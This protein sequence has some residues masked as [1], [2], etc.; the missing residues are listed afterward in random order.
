M[1][2]KKFFIALL[3]APLLLSACS[4]QDSGSNASDSSNSAPATVTVTENEAS[5]TNSS[6]AEATSSSA[7]SSSEE[8]PAFAIIATVLA[9]HQDGIITSIDREYSSTNYEV[10]VVVGDEHLELKVTNDGQITQDDRDNDD[11]DIQEARTAT[12]TVTQALEQALEQHPDGVV[13]SA[14]L[15]DDDGQLSWDVD[16]DDASGNDLAE[17]KIP[18]V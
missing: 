9:E 16:L 13:D 2:N 8:D 17:V 11:E 4:S 15:D 18:A 7:A 10:D 6:P 3:S 14:E 5:S 1:K 12:V